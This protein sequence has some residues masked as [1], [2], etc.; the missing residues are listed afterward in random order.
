M[1]IK[2]RW[3]NQFKQ[4]PNQSNFH[5]QVRTIF[6]EDPFFKLLQCYQEVPVCDLIPNYKS[7]MHR[8]DFYIEELNVVVELHGQ[9]HYKLT[10]RGN[11]GYDR[12]KIE[13]EKSKERD[14]SKKNAALSSN[15]KYVA[16][17]YKYYNKLNPKLL[18]TLILDA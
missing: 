14:T 18:K 1:P 13:F 11:I 7:N 4:L 17:S 16:I 15:I 8:Y 10:D 5:E 2:S 3:T 12:A 6:A 9:Q